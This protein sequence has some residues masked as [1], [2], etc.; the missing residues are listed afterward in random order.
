MFNEVLKEKRTQDFVCQAQTYEQIIDLH[1]PDEQTLT[2][3]PGGV[4]ISSSNASFKAHY[5]LRGQTLHI[6]RRMV[7]RVPGQSCS[8]QVAVDMAPV[9]EA[10]TKQF[11]WRPQFTQP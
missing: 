4:D 3:A 5:D 11:N 10:A 7:T 8:P 9:I 1:L 6:E 2:E